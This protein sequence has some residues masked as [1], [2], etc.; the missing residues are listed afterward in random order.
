MGCSRKEREGK[1]IDSKLHHKE[2]ASVIQA[3]NPP[4]TEWC[5]NFRKQNLSS[6]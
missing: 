1:A 2:T 6:E 3:E 4:V 5:G